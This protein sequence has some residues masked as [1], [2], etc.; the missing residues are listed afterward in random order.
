MGF[1]TRL[2]QPVAPLHF[3]AEVAASLARRKQLAVVGGPVKIADVA[4]DPDLALQM[5]GDVADDRIRHRLVDDAD[6]VDKKQQRRVVAPAF[7]VL[8]AFRRQDSVER[9]TPLSLSSAARRMSFSIRAE[10]NLSPSSGIPRSIVCSALRPPVTTPMLDA[11]I[12]LRS[13]Q[14]PLSSSRQKRIARK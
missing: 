7:A 14:W 10:P 8:N 1:L 12:F 2:E 11:S 13:S 3:V 4:A 9:L 6:R 5:A